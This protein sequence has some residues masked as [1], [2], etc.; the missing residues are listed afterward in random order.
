MK[1]KSALIKSLGGYLRL[2]AAVGTALLS[3]GLPLHARAAS[4][5]PVGTWDVAISGSRQGLAL[6][7]FFDGGTPDTRTFNIYEIIVPKKPSSSSSS[8]DD[9]R[10]T[11]GDDSRSGSTGGSGSSSSTSVTV[12]TNL[13][14]EQSVL[15]GQWGFDVNGKIIGVFG[16]A[17]AEVCTPET[18]TVTSVTNFPDGSVGFTT[19]TIIITNCV[20]VTNGVSFTGT[21]VPGK[22]LTLSAHAF[23]RA[24]VL[25]GIPVNTLTNISGNYNGARVEGG[26]SS[27]EFFALSVSALDF[28]NN[29]IYDVHGASGAYSYNSPGGHALLSRR[30]KIA[31][32]IPLDPDGKVLRATSG[33]FDL[34]RL[35]FSTQGVEQPDGPLHFIKFN[36]A[37]SP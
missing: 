31:F 36:G 9:S 34:H 2:G 22:R 20:G 7:Q 35:R 26:Q 14:G 25:S 1:T 8:S 24:F 4:G 6:M 11:G 16:E 37:V 27:I 21:A 28:G 33:G 15:N 17:L 29:L 32:A 19:N 30:G 23:S 3:C 12:T 18:F 10:N 13:F 5:S